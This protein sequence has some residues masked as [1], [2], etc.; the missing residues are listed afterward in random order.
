MLCLFKWIG[1]A[2]ILGIMMR[3]MKLS[4]CGMVGS[5]GT[6]DDDVEI[7]ATIVL[8]DSKHRW[9]GSIPGHKQWRS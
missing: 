9:G 3:Y 2:V 6:F 8:V 4:N 7:A 5:Q 1:A